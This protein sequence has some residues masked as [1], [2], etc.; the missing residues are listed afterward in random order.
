MRLA[1][2]L[3][4]LDS[5]GVELE[6]VDGRLAVDA[7]GDLS[8]ELVGELRNLKAELLRAL[9]P[10]TVGPDGWPA[11]TVDFD[12][13]KPC[14]SCGRLD[15]WQSLAGN[16]HCRRCEPPEMAQRVRNKVAWRKMKPQEA[17]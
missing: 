14:P 15:A 4:R 3:V 12:D 1:D 10:A 13:I 5:Q 9:T 17:A 16:W 7:S 6:A 11:D 8:P 2:L